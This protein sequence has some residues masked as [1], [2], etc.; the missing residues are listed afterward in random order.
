M[1]WACFNASPDR[2]TP[3]PFPYLSRTERRQALRPRVGNR[4]QRNK[5]DPSVIV[6]NEIKRCQHPHFTHFFKKQKTRS[7]WRKSA[8]MII[9]E[10][11]QNKSAET[12]GDLRRLAETCGDLRRVA[13]IR[14]YLPRSAE[15]GNCRNRQKS[16]NNTDTGELR[17]ILWGGLFEIAG[18]AQRQSKKYASFKSIRK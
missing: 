13:E 11:L 3:G 2:S 1:S 14:G 6:S 5:S 4:F 8:K 9:C 17:R 18:G 15:I 16:E 7:C 10:N 12:C